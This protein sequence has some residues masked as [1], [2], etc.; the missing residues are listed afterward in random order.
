MIAVGRSAMTED[1]ANSFRALALA[2][3][4]IVLTL[5]VPAAAQDEPRYALV[6]GNSA[7][8]AAP[9]RNPQNDARAMASVLRETGF[10]VT[11]Q[12]DLPFDKFESTIDAFVAGLP[13]NAVGLFYYAGHAFQYDGRNYLLPT[14]MKIG[15]ADSMIEKAVAVD[16]ILTK[17][18]ESGAGLSIFILDA[19]R[20]NPFVEGGDVGKGLAFMEGTGG[21]VVIGFATQAG[22]VAF[23][24]SGIN[25]PYTGA[26]ISAIEVQGR[27][28][29]DVFRAVRSSVRRWTEGRQ[30]PYMSASVEREFFFRPGDAQPEDVQV[31]EINFDD[32]LSAVQSIWWQA[33]QNSQE[34]S[35]FDQ[36]LRR[37]PA[38]D[39]STEA[40]SRKLELATRGITLMPVD[41][42]AYILPEDRQAAAGLSAVVTPCDVVASDPDDPQ[43]IFA[44]TPWGLTNTRLALRECADALAVDPDN[45]RLQFQFGRVLDILGRYDEA[46]R[47]YDLAAKQDYSAA[48]VNTGFLHLTGNIGAQSYEEAYKYYWKAAQLGN[49]RARTNIGEMYLKGWGVEQNPDEAVIWYKLASDNGWPNALDGLGNLYKAGPDESG[50][51]APKDLNEAIRLYQVASEL[52][53]TNAMNN[54]GS[55]YLSD[56]LGEPNVELGVQ[57]LSKAADRGNKFAPFNLGRMYRDGRM[58]ERDYA[59][60]LEYFQLSADF[61][62]SPAYVALGRMY[63]DGNGV[64]K[65]VDE[66]AFYY[67]L[68]R[69]SADPK[70]TSQLEDAETRLDSL[71]LSPQQLADAE[72]R[73]DD[74]VRENGV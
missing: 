61:G 25:S 36:F 21:E 59:K 9:L 1:F 42:S 74:W 72:A 7:Y 3:I 70:Q 12:E 30:R 66:A 45:P 20:D 33:I 53:S 24:G 31:A 8:E 5:A 58:L 73:A 17:Y 26:L 22:Q 13:D 34:P 35:D 47:F 44:G 69:T 11:L 18:Q 65:D 60:A 39:F 57:W 4:S 56:A 14:D 38:S 41:Y 2:V 54:L 40:E 37:F 51:G 62:Y 27:E 19:C 50:K 29:S 46:V 52:G 28:I 55:L 23:D 63:Q 67:F 48:S 15:S 16:R 10:D 71:E 64:E 6:I 68:G 43:R 49:L 32:I